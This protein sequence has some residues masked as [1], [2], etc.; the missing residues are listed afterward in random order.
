MQL[1]SKVSLAQFSAAVA[2]AATL[3]L[4]PMHSWAHRNAWMHDSHCTRDPSR[5]HRRNLAPLRGRAT[6]PLRLCHRLPRQRPGTF[7]QVNPSPIER[8]RQGCG[9]KRA[10]TGAGIRLLLLCAGPVQ[11][12][13]VCRAPRGT[14]VPLPPRKA[15]RLSHL[16]LACLAGA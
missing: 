14:P 9:R 3:G 13:R 2:A 11:A 10:T 8:M 15:T 12:A 5:E 1:A 7:P 4:W 16:C 6:G